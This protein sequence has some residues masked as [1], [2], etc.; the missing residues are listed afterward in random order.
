MTDEIIY[1]LKTYL[2]NTWGPRFFDVI[3]IL[4]KS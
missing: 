4:R 2:P 3:N 1:K